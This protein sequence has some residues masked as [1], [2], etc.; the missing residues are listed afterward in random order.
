MK[1]PILIYEDNSDLRE[2]LK[3]LINISAYYQ[4]MGAFENSM[5]VVSDVLE[6]RPQ[7]ILM[8]ID[9]PSRNGIESVRLIREVDKEVK[10]I[11]LTVFEDNRHVIEAVIAGA[12]GYLLKKYCFDELFNAISEALHG[13][14]PLSANVARIVLDH[15]VQT[16]G[17]TIE[18]FDF[19][20]KEKEILG[21][22]VK[23][24][25]Y[26]KISSLHNIGYETVKKHIRNIY[27]KLQVHNQA[28]AV[29]KALK[30]RIV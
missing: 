26:K 14:A 15:L 18:K 10:I 19:T 25:T 30:N 11:M 1:T 13:G 23:G 2:A 28:E 27:E 22:L 17:G 21:A 16:N 12:S 3:Q 4:C 5:R 29:A 9:L 24:Y 20:L 7:V 8:D 6:L